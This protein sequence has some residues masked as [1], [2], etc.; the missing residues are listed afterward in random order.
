VRCEDAGSRRYGATRVGRH[1]TLYALALKGNFG[2][3]SSAMNNATVSFDCS[4][5]QNVYA[6]VYPNQPYQIY[7]GRVFWSAPLT[8][9]DSKAGTLIHEMSHFNVVAGTD[10]VVYGQTGARSL[11]LS[12]PEDAIRNADSHEY[13]AENTPTLP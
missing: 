2:K 11:A 10:D 12:D 9:T 5:K 1:R 4:S 8:G 3:I 6:Y 13:F 7:L